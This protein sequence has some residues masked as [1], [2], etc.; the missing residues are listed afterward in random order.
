MRYAG[1]KGFTSIAQKKQS[2]RPLNLIQLTALIE[3]L[4]HEKKLQVETGVPVVDL[5]EFGY[6]K[7]LG[8][9]T[10][11]KAVKVKVDKCSESALRKLKSVG[12]D[13]IMNTV[14]RET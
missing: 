8:A 2:F 5:R 7:L 11:S 12:G 3:R 9:G 13:A 10:I 1:K 6:T 4:E 14:P